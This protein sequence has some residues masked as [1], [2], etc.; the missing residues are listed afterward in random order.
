MWFLL[1]L[2]PEIVAVRQG[3][4]DVSVSG[5]RLGDI[6]ITRITASNP[7]RY[8]I[9]PLRFTP[10][11]QGKILRVAIATSS[12]TKSDAGSPNTGDWAGSLEAGGEIRILIVGSGEL[13]LPQVTDLFSGQYPAFD[14]EGRLHQAA[15][16]VR[17]LAEVTTQRYR[18]I[19]YG[20]LGVL[21][22]SGLA[23][24]IIWLRRR[25]V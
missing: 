18:Y 5:E 25:R 8:A 12:G 22:V 16:R 1:S 20:G 11:F 14:K 19:A 7:G 23:V 13:L 21:I 9:E 4:L 2:L 17:D 3:Y 24:G 10:R 15:I 6:V